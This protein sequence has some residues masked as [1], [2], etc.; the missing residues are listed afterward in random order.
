L[1]FVAGV[2]GVLAFQNLRKRLDEESAD[3]LLDDL[4]E[5]MKALESRI[6]DIGATA[7]RRVRKT[8]VA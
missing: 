7:K 6:A 5:K 1:G 3:G 4:G 8:S 2:A